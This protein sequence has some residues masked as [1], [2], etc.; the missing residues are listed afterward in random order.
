MIGSRGVSAAGRHCCPSDVAAK[1]ATF[2]FCSGVKSRETLHSPNTV[3]QAQPPSHTNAPKMV[4]GHCVNVINV[5]S[6][7]SIKISFCSQNIA[8]QISCSPFSVARMCSLTLGRENRCHGLPFTVR[9]PAASFSVCNKH[10]CTR[11]SCSSSEGR[12]KQLVEQERYDLFPLR[13]RTKVGTA[14]I[15]LFRRKVE[16]SVLY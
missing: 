8:N 12:N 9:G 15:S 4:P 6:L 16:G 1:K 5:H 7:N 11:R 14:V 2:T 3:S 10:S 13:K